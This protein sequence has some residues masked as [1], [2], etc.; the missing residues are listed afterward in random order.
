M[1][2]TPSVTFRNPF[3]SGRAAVVHDQTGA[4]AREL[5]SQNRRQSRPISVG[6]CERAQSKLS[7][8]AAFF[9]PP[10]P[11]PEPARADQLAPDWFGPPAGILPGVAA[12]ELVLAQTA[13]AV[14]YTSYVQAYPTGFEFDLFVV[15]DPN[16]GE[17]LDLQAALFGHHHRPGRH[18]DRAEALAPE[19][20]RL[21]V[22]F[23]DRRKAT[24]T[25]SSLRMETQ[26][27][28]PVLRPGGGGTSAHSGS[29]DQWVWPLPSPGPVSFVCE[30]PAAGIAL[31]RHEIDGDLIL[32]AA[33]R[34]QAHFPNQPSSGHVSGSVHSHSE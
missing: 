18:T 33:R 30:W 14:I 9:E 2:D 29:Q 8:V 19:R 21:G 7:V 10:P 20:L 6:K 22:E 1:G 25:A 15:T 28:G 17:T 13:T 16:H 31:T 4:A 12:L 27:P 32:E 26:P 23:S 24:N 11:E 5:P 3:I 34:A